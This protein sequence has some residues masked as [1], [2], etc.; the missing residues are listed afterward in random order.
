[1]T[2]KSKKDSIVISRIG[3]CNRVVFPKEVLDALALQFDDKLLIQIDGGKR[4]LII[5]KLDDAVHS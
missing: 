2:E 5:R 1:M 3:S 4:Q